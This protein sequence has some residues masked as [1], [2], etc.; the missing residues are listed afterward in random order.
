MAE[1]WT[2]CSA[3][4]EQLTKEVRAVPSRNLHFWRE[5]TEE[6]NK[7]KDHTVMSALLGKM[8]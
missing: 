7:E 5:L 2:R 1:L 3:R 4:T 8:E 6:E